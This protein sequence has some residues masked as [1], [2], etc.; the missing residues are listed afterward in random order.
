[1]SDALRPVPLQELRLLPAGRRWS[2][3]Q[4]LDDLDSLTPVRGELEA[5]HQ[6]TVLEVRARAETIVNLCCDRCL[7]SYNHP[8]AT[9]SHELIELGEP[10]DET[11]AVLELDSDVPLETLD[12]RSSF[13]PAR[14]L[15]EQLHLQLPLRNDCG[16]DCPGPDL[17]GKAPPAG[18]PSSTGGGDPRW[19]ALRN[20]PLP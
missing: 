18:H 3:D 5:R 1:M 4:P 2:V 11:G 10:R 12:P 16:L 8:L 20:L 7:G 9:D 14:W 6:G 17:P 15:F 19:A 13:D